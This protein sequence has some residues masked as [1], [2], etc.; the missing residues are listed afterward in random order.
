MMT[1]L[2]FILSKQKSQPVISSNDELDSIPP[3]KQ[4]FELGILLNSKYPTGV[5][6]NLQSV[7][8]TNWLKY[9]QIYGKYNYFSVRLLCFNVL[10]D[11]FVSSTLS[12]VQTIEE[13]LADF[14]CKKAIKELMKL[15][16]DIE[17]RSVTLKLMN[18]IK[19]AWDTEML[20][21]L[22]SLKLFEGIHFDKILLEIN[23]CHAYEE[24]KRMLSDV[25]IQSDITG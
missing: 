23:A 19:K 14:L 24:N 10:S 11:C 4:M 6:V 20:R 12:E 18:E 7:F 16:H 13:S 8:D 21:C 9:L 17:N 2:M 3:S 5:D 1:C 22:L 25:L 15:F